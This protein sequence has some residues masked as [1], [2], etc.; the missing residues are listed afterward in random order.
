MRIQN[1]KRDKKETIIN[2]VEAFS[3]EKSLF[4]TSSD[5]N[6]PSESKL[7]INIIAEHIAI[8]PKSAGL[9]ILAIMAAHKKP[10]I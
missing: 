3:V 4:I 8:S 10:I 5:D 1:I 6:P 2:M 7:H 9:A